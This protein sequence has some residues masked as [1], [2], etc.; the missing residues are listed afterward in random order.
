MITEKAESPF[1][2]IWPFDF[3]F[4]DGMSD[5]ELEGICSEGQGQRDR[6]RFDSRWLFWASEMYSQGPILRRMIG[7]PRW[8]PLPFFSDHGVNLTSKLSKVENASAARIHATWSKWRLDPP[9]RPR[10]RIIGLPHPWAWA[11][12]ELGISKLSD[13]SGILIFVPHGLPGGTRDFDW[14]PYIT[15]IVKECGAGQVTAICLAMHDVRAGIHK[16][17]R[18]HKLPIFS[19]GDT[20]S[21][22]MYLRF[23]D[24]AR[25]FSSAVST[26]I[27]TQTFICQDLGLDYRLIGAN[28]PATW[29]EEQIDFLDAS[30]IE[31]FNS[32]F[33]LDGTHGEEKATLTSLALNLDRLDFN[34]TLTL[35]FVLI[36]ELARLLPFAFKRLWQRLVFVTLTENRKHLFANR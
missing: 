26:E 24:I 21:P 35:K 22:L 18:K 8:L 27:G 12:R 29:G 34:P 17:L 36:L 28:Q 11:R 19:A 9:Q 33:H 15:S 2:R 20:A 16:K 14:D 13:A 3:N 6:R 32:V 25:R 5:S 1:E 10:K 23:F 4:V 7:W 31:T 30:R